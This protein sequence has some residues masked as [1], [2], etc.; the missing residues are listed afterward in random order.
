M[1]NFITVTKQIIYGDEMQELPLISQVTLYVILALMGFFT[2][3][4]FI[5]QYKILRGGAYE[6]PDG[7]K[8][9]WHEQKSH[10]GIALADLVMACPLTIAGIMFLFIEP[11]WG[12]YM[13]ALTSFWFIWANIMTTATSLRFQKPKK[14][15]IWFITFPLGAIV[16]LAY[17]IWTVIHFDVIYFS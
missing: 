13:L 15:F 9:D 1:T 14:T 4:I 2:I 10:Y 3:L 8:D 6:N 16:G 7:S 11:R 17:I 12:Y 5:W